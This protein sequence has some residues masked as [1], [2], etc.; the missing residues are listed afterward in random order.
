MLQARNSRNCG[1]RPPNLFDFLVGGESI[2]LRASHVKTER[3]CVLGVS[4]KLNGHDPWAY[5]KDVPAHL[6]SRIDDL[7]PHRWQPQA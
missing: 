3:F 7:Q 1:I 4:A 5:L 2:D 6:N